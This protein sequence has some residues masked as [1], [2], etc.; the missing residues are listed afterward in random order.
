MIKRNT[1]NSLNVSMFEYRS[2]KLLADIKR[3]LANCP[4]EKYE[5]NLK[6]D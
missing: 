2:I 3:N 6:S 1:P 5:L 4:K